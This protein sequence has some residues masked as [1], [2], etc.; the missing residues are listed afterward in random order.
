[1]DK[2]LQ[3]IMTFYVSAM[4]I[5]IN[6]GLIESE[7]LQVYSMG[8]TNCDSLDLRKLLSS[9]ST[10]EPQKLDVV[11]FKSSISNIIVYFAEK[12][13]S[14]CVNFAFVAFVVHC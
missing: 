9:S 7:K 12:F 2:L 13:C 4:S 8:A 10:N 3:N 5:V 1:M 11:D 14:V 6:N